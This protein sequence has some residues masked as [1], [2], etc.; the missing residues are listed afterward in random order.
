M[1]YEKNIKFVIGDYPS[2][3]RYVSVVVRLLLRGRLIPREF[4]PT[5]CYLEELITRG[6][7]FPDIPRVLFRKNETAG[8]GRTVAITSGSFL[9]G[10]SIEHR[11]ETA[12]DDTCQP[13]IVSVLQI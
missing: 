10:V 3:F 12:L 1:S 9:C 5:E 7:I 11:R 8:T 4:E 6:A 13:S 2:F